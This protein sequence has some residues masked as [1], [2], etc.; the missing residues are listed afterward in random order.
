MADSS[1]FNV[2]L[3]KCRPTKWIK[4]LYVSI[5]ILFLAS[6]EGFETPLIDL[7]GR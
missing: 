1:I 3:F 4:D 2:P 5:G 7:Y 6:G